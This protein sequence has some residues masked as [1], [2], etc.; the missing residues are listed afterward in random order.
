VSDW[1]WTPSPEFAESTNV[2]RF[3]RKLGFSDREAFLA[4]SRDH[5]E[6]FWDAVVRETGIEWFQPYTKVLDVSRGI[7]W[8]QWFVG[9]KLNIVHNTLDRWAES[10]RTAVR[11]ESESGAHREITFAELARHVNRLANH[12]N[13]LGLKAGD[14]VACVMPMIP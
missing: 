1:I 6:E 12:L 8:A 14:R 11:W 2:W 3:M 5:L 9:G 4:Y 13:S 7:E 10:E